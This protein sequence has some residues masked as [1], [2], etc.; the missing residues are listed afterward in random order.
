MKS[1]VPGTFLSLALL[2]AGV[3]HADTFGSDENAFTID[4]VT[5]GDPGN[6]PDVA[7]EPNPA[8]GVAYEYRLAAYEVSEDMLNKAN[9]LGGLNIEH[10]QRGPSKPATSVSWYEAAQFVNWLN[11]DTGHP[12]AYKF[13]DDGAFQLWEPGDQGYDP[14]NL[15]RN[16]LSMYFLPSADEWYKAAYYDPDAGVYHDYPTGSNAPPFPVASGVLANTAV[17]DGQ[18]GPAEVMLAGGLSPYGTMGQGGNV[19]EWEETSL[20]LMNDSPVAF[21]GVRGGG[22]SDLGDI[23]LKAIREGVQKDGK[24]QIIGVRVASAP[25]P[26]PEPGVLVL[27]AAAGL[28]LGV[29]RRRSRVRRG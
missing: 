27:L 21:S 1:I 2:Y 11:A 7:G 20:D 17:F 9:A 12:P 3:A 13:D 19:R 15:Y 24:V 29:A 8:G 25:Q 26:V 28:G 14:G 10:D 6:A 4:F 23:L 16:S 18:A 5:I 22:W